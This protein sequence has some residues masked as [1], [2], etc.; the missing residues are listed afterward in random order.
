VFLQR[1]GEAQLQRH[2]EHKTELFYFID[3]L[4]GGYVFLCDISS[5]GRSTTDRFLA[6][7]AWDAGPGVS[8]SGPSRGPAMSSS[9][10][11]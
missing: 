3:V 10:T 7:L 11:S 8:A 2:V 9:S 4:P 5:G 6:W 1:P